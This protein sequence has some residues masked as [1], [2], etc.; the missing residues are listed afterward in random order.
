MTTRASVIVGARTDVGRARELNE[1]SLGT[2]ERMRI[3]PALLARKGR[4]YAVAD[5]MGGHAAGDVASQQ[6]IVTLFREYY[7]DPSLDVAKSLER[8]FEVAN[9]VV[10]EQALADPMKAGMGTT[11]VA[12]VVQGDRLTVANV[13]DSR[14]YLIRGRKAQQLTR[15]HSWVAEQVLAGVLG[16]KEARHHE[17]RSLITRSVGTKPQVKTD[18]FTHKLRSH[19][20]IFLCS[21]GL[22]NQVDDGTI[23]QIISGKQPQA[24]ADDLVQKANERGGPDNITAVV[25]RFLGAP[26]RSPLPLLLL[27][28]GLIVALTL[29]TILTR[30]PDRIYVTYFAT[31]TPTVT[32]TSTPTPTP[33]DTL[34]P[35]PTPTDTPTPTNTPTPTPTK[36][37]TMTPTATNTPTPTYTPTP[38]HTATPTLTNTPTATPLPTDTPTWMPTASDTPTP[39]GLPTHTPTLA[40]AESPASEATTADTPGPIAVPALT[41]APRATASP[42]SVSEDAAAVTQQP[43]EHWT[44]KWC[45]GPSAAGGIS[46]LALLLN[47]SRTKDDDE[48]AIHGE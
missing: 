24:A 43:P 31:K 37:P 8:A 25:V 14:A 1:D 42:A 11:L 18:S 2:P 38:T 28:G 22:S 30:L 26:S 20:A 27:G 6:A 3:D 36:P 35:T 33:T 23:G 45:V 44:E 17:Y 46:L 47:R 7:A 21:D 9:A 13:G 39:V 5:G 12:A 19:D 32:P 15:D 40:L 4:L 48:E 34:T 16:P 10:H 41:V 29:L